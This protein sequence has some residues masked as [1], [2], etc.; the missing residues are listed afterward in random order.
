MTALGGAGPLP[1]SNIARDL[2]IPTVIV[3]QFPAQFCALGMLMTDIRHDDVRT[4]LRPLAAEDLRGVA[5]VFEELVDDGMR[6][7]EEHGVEPAARRLQRWLGPL[8]A[9]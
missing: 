3:P 5:T 7:L 9:M 1:R 2:H 8:S 6:R 4:H